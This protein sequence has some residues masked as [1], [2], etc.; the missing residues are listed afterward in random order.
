MLKYQIL[1]GLVVV[2]ETTVGLT[3]HN[4]FYIPDPEIRR[5]VNITWKEEG[6]SRPNRDSCPDRTPT[7][8]PGP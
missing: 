5:G 8:S 7:L 4:L 3:P 1:N 2:E 6:D